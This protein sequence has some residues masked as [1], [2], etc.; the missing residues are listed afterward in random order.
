M[1]AALRFV[2]RRRPQ[3]LLPMRANIQFLLRFDGGNNSSVFVDSSPYVR[4]VTTSGAPTQ[5]TDRQMLGVSAFLPGSTRVVTVA[6]NTALQQATG[7][8]ILDAFIWNTAL[9]SGPDPW[10]VIKGVGAGFSPW[11]LVYQSSTGNFV[12]YGFRASDNSSAY[13]LSLPGAQ[14][15]LNRLARLTLSRHGPWVTLFLDGEIVARAFLDPTVA[16]FSSTANVHIGNISS[17][18]RPWTN[19]F[20][21]QVM[22][23]TGQGVSTGFD[24]RA[25]L[26]Y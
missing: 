2:T 6:H 13:F 23:V 8:W 18:I 16:L 25:A 5:S 14:F 12:G 7:D 21:D 3:P 9:P 26:V 22:F 15:P 17:G 20:I 4:S 11:T 1:S 10:L 19:G 24:P